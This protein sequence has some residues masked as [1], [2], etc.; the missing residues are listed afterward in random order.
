[1]VPT[2]APNAG[3][4]W[5]NAGWLRSERAA[6]IPLL[7]KSHDHNLT[8]ASPRPY[9]SAM[10][11]RWA[12]AAI[13]TFSAF[14]AFGLAAGAGA[15]DPPQQR[16]GWDARAAA[17]YLDKRAD[18]WLHWPTAAR[19]HETQCVSCHTA[20]PYALARPALRMPLGEQSAAAPERLL[21]A[22]V[23]KRVSLW[24]EVEPF[25]P[26]QT[27]GLPKTSESRG[28]EAVMNALILATRDAP[29][30][31]PQRRRTEGVRQSVA[32]AVQG[33][34]LQGHV[35]VAELSLR[36]VGISRRGVFRRRTR[37]ARRGHGARRL[38]VRP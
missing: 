1:M 34:R 2:P 17:A 4:R 35:G 12:G 22:N 20:L 33:G 25:Y 23:I 29:T 24:N 5:M 13:I 18:W 19:D 36:A 11:A 37:G 21:Y 10:N 30:G 32:A 14:T 28:T 38:R 15:V 7:D 9:R 8:L 3:R 16:P 26:D 27:R 31:E 6:I